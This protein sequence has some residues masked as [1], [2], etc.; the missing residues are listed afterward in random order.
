MAPRGLWVRFFI[1][2]I[3]FEKLFDWAGQS[4]LRCGNLLDKGMPIEGL[5]LYL[6]GSIPVRPEIK[7]LG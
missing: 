5:E 6:L 1:K 2:I 7:L 4:F 3:E